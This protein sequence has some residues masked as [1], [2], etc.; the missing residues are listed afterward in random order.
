VLPSV[1][2]A[3][4]SDIIR[5]QCESVG[6]TFYL[7]DSVAKFTDGVAETK[8][9]VTLEFDILVLAVGVRPNSALIKDAGGACGRA[10]T[11]DEHCAT[12]LP[13]IYAAGDCTES[14]DTVTGDI[15]VMAILPNA[16]IQGETAGI[17]MAG[18]KYEFT[19][20]FPHNAIGFFG[21]H[22]LSAGSYTGDV[23]YTR[24]GANYKKL[25]YADDRLVGFILIG[26]KHPEP[27]ETPVYDRAGIY[28]NIIREGTP[29]SE[30]DFAAIAEKPGL[31]AFSRATRDEYLGGE[32]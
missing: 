4:A 23:Y 14:R 31:I 28:T 17:N 20:A 22:I 3:E 26:D 19:K 2:D 25:F 21:K 24:D 5:A 13:D 7:G 8:N 15:K 18:V 27:G 29:L 1:L 32:R 30:L 11:I 16:Y 12:S 9:G 10:I 6:I